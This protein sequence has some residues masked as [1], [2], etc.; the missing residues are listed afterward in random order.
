MA[1]LRMEIKQCVPHVLNKQYAKLH[2]LTHPKPALLESI[3]LN[4]QP[5]VFKSQGRLKHPLGNKT[6]LRDFLLT[7]GKQKPENFNIPSLG[8]LVCLRG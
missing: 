3:Y 7:C 2:Q 8:T 4:A 1:Q 6:Y 5:R